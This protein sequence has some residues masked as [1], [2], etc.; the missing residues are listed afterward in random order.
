MGMLVTLT[1]LSLLAL[2]M[3]WSSLLGGQAFT[4]IAQYPDKKLYKAAT[5]LKPEERPNIPVRMT[6]DYKKTYSD[7]GVNKNSSKF[8]EP[9][10]FLSPDKSQIFINSKHKGYKNPETLSATL[11]HEGQHLNYKGINPEEDETLARQKQI[12]VLGRYGG[13][14]REFI[15]TMKRIYGIK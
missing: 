1:S 7:M 14:H 2:S 9:V 13:R 11:A 8:N 15:E 10:A 12:E 3:D 6:D 5:M 4:D